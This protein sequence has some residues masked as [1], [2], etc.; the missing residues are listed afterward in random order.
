LI[1]ISKAIHHFSDVE[2]FLKISVII[3]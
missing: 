3:F 1:D 2:D